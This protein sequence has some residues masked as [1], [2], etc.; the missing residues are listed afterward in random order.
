[1]QKLQSWTLFNLT[2][3]CASTSWMA[4]NLPSNIV[5]L[6][7]RELKDLKLLS[8]L[9]TWTSKKS[10][11][12]FVLEASPKEWWCNHLWINAFEIKWAILR[13]FGKEPLQY[14][15]TVFLNC[16][17]R[18]IAWLWRCASL[19]FYLNIWCLDSYLRLEI[20]RPQPTNH[21]LIF[22]GAWSFT[23][24]W[25]LPLISSYKSEMEIK[26]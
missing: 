25:L 14:W 17:W 21:L 9:T 20:F 15:R 8:F 19:Y 12:S 6:T 7:Q 2:K 13:P 22:H 24:C 1:M 18:M 23:R 4:W 5:L 3:E 16:L 26:C 11:I 10:L